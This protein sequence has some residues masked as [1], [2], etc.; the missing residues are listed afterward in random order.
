MNRNSERVDSP[1]VY[2]DSGTPAARMP[3]ASG[4]APLGDDAISVAR[5]TKIG[6]LR[7][8]C[9]RD[10]NNDAACLGGVASDL[11]EMELF[12]AD[13]MR[14]ALREADPSLA[15]IEEFSGPIQTLLKLSKEITSIKQVEYRA[16]K[17][18]DPAVRIRLP[19]LL[20]TI[21]EESKTCSPTPKEG[22]KA[23]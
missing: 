12:L 9:L 21:G 13:A 23:P 1:S 17:Y 10:V 14:E 7:R 3:E 22:P 2:E 11:M 15:T 5:H 16:R 4:D 6:A 18:G 8:E 20:P 19:T